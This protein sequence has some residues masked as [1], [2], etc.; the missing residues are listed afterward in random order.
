MRWLPS[1]GLLLLLAGAAGAQVPIPTPRDTVPRGG[2]A[3]DT[4]AAD[5]AGARPRVPDAV[6]D[7]IIRQLMQ[8]EGY[9]AT[10]YEADTAVYRAD[11]RVLRL[12]GTA[13]VQ[14]EGDRLNADSIIYRQNDEM[15]EAYGSPKVSGRQAQDLSG[16]Q[17]YYNLRDRRATAVGA[18]TTI[19][20]EASW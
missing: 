6:A 11:Q 14:R 19:T 5:T 3:R 10:E 20:Q 12:R 18:R 7:S 2:V 15:V 9:V 17:L 4:A 8:R 13:Q 16:D 1:L